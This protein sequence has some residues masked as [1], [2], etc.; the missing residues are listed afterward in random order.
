MSEDFLTYHFPDNPVMPGMLILEA[1]IQLG[2]WLIAVSTDF[3][4]KGILAQVERAKFKSLVRAGDKIEMDV[5]ITRTAEEQVFFSGKA[6]VDGSLTSI[7][8]FSLNRRNME[9]FEDPE[10]ARVTF[11]LL[12]ATHYKETKK[13]NGTVT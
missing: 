4:L 2:S 8:E 5:S 12:N 13:E 1:M 6:K 11:G 7:A 3:K 9:I 10:T